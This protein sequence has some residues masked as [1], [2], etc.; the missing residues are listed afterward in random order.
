MSMTKNTMRRMAP[1]ISAALAASLLAPALPLQAA[2]KRAPAV[3]PA[4][5]VTLNFVN[6]DIEAVTRAISAMLGKPILVD[7]RVKGNLTLTAEQ[8]VPPAEA[9][10]SYLAALRGLG[11]A[12]VESG[13]LLK[14][15]PE[16]EAKLLT[17]SVTVSG[18]VRARGDQVQTQIFK[19]NHENGANIVPVLRPLIAANN[20]INYNPGNNT[21]VITDYA[22]NLQ[23]VARI[24]AALD[25]PAATD[26]EVIPLKHAVAADIAALVQKLAD[27]SSAS[28]AAAAGG[29][30]TA[31]GGSVSVLADSRSNSLILR[32]A[33]PSKLATLRAMVAKLDQPG[34]PNGQIHVVYLKNADATRLATVLRA[35]FSTGSG[36]SSSG[37]NSNS[38]GSFTGGGSN[39]SSGVSASVVSGSSSSSS[40]SSSSGSLSSASTQVSAAASPSTGGF[41]QADPATNSLII[42]APEPMYRQVRAVIDQLDTR[43]AQIYVE[44]LIVKVDASKAGQFGVQWQQIFG[45]S[46]SSVVSGGGTNFGS[47]YAN[48]INLSAA[49]ASGTDGLAT[50]ASAGTIPTGLNLGFLRK[51]GS[52]YTL[53]AIANFLESQSGTNVLSTPNLVALD[54]EEADLVIGQNVP[55]V[56]GSYT[57]TST[58][59]STTS[60][61]QTYERKDVG[62]RLKIKGQVGEGGTVRMKVY[63]ENSSVV[64]TSST[65]GPT[66]DKSAVETSVVLEDGQILVLGGL[67]KDEYT[68]SE[69]KVPGLGSLPV[70]GNLFKSQSRSRVKTNLMI[71]LRPMILR[72]PD[73]AEQLTLDRYQAI[74]A[75]QQ[76]VQ[77]EKKTFLPETGAPLLPEKPASATPPSAPASAP[78][79]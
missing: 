63:Q 47:G 10:Q 53:G 71:F 38:S 42:T 41:V 49:T 20:I 9:Y 11:W 68:D 46:G 69:D 75:Y 72:A 21:L 15:V 22:D 17:S 43:R 14:L 32:A 66:L 29:Q 5:P 8:P 30:G 65:S 19:L 37:A 58:S 4:T 35:A 78:K 56:T 67:L 6:A 31:S 60:P 73:S 34:D 24:I 62:L 70:L 27:G 13:G 2:T 64:S 33:N 55:F 79:Q 52:Y 77:S 3:K 26:L 39:S 36:A 54:N 59:S 16:G 40:S 48:I 23:R 45:S 7:P 61:F 51:F 28:T 1:S 44:A 18:E 50:A 25:Q 57:T 76:G 74:R 12:M